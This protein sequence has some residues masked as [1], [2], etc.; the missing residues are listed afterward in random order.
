MNRLSASNCKLCVLQ[1][2]LHKYFQKVGPL[3]GLTFDEDFTLFNQFL[4][5]EL[6]EKDGKIAL[7]YH[8]YTNEGEKTTS[9]NLLK[10]FNNGLKAPLPNS[11]NFETPEPCVEGL[12]KSCVFT[13]M[14]NKDDREEQ[15]WQ[16]WA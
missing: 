12:T 14:Q 10:K 2:D 8:F 5:T 13:L 16:V 1:E 6:F 3:A 15:R 11:S 9:D 7:K 4:I